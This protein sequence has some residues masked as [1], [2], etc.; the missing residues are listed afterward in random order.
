MPESSTVLQDG[1]PT[2]A[3]P[4]RGRPRKADATA[5]REAIL[6]A[7]EALFARHG[8]HGVTLREVARAAGVDGALLHYY[9]DTKRG[10]FD[11]VFLRRA[12]VLNSRRL[13]ALNAYEASEGDDVT[14]EGALQAFLGPVLG[15]AATGDPGWLAYCALIAQ[16][17]NTPEWGGEAMARYFDPVVLR[18]LQ[19]VKR[20]LPNASEADLFWSYHMLS[21]ALMLT[22][23]ESGRLDR[24]SG[25]LCRSDDMEQ[26]RAHMIAFAAAGFRA[27]CP[28]A[29]RDG[30]PRSFSAVLTEP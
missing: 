20:A 21:G 8:L 16:V 26:A 22:I 6:D 19:V 5:A 11:A 1:K 27:A 3:R 28:P 14:V 29:R 17:S 15:A 4:R 2:S 18:L 24:L 13:Q 7:A 12:E 10:L 30:E 23:S 9:F 25:G